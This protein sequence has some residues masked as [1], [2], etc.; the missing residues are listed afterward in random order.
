[1]TDLIIAITF[2]SPCAVFMALGY[3]GKN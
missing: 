3:F 1:M 2:L